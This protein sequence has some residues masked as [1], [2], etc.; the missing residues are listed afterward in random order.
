MHQNVPA[1]FLARYMYAA[2]VTLR[3]SKQQRMWSAEG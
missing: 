2:P 3:V 1:G